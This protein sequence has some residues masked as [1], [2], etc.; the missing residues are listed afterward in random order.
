[1]TSGKNPTGRTIIDLSRAKKDAPPIEIT[2]QPKEASNSDSNFF[3]KAIFATATTCIAGALAWWYFF[4]PRPNNPNV[5]GNSDDGD[6]GGG[7]GGGGDNGDGGENV[8]GS[9]A[10]L[11]KGWKQFDETEGKT[12]TTLQ[13]Y[14]KVKEGN[15]NSNDGNK[16]RDADGDSGGS[17]LIEV[18]IFI[19]EVSATKFDIYHNINDAFP[20]F[21]LEELGKGALD[22]YVH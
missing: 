7:G 11:R 6:D 2:E 13:K 5:H 18:P 17:I 14:V 20:M 16:D 3:L 10:W 8:E 9:F 15:V 21:Y 22:V 19:T 4:Y 12:K 1:M